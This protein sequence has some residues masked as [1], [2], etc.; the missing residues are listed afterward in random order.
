MTRNK[1]NSIEHIISKALI[2]S[3][4]SHEEV[5]LMINE[6]Q[7]WFRP[8]ES[9]RANDVQLSDIERDRSIGNGKRVLQS[10]RLGLQL[11]T[12]V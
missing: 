5:K 11:K 6:E 3:D 4:I 7:N 12:N 9:I 2:D 10:E 1:L 8:K